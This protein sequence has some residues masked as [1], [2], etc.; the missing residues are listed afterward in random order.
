MIVNTGLNELLGVTLDGDSQT[1]DWRVGLID[2]SGFVSIYG[3]DSMASHP[4]WVENTDYDETSRPSWNPDAPADQ[5][6]SNS[7][8]VEFTM[9]DTKTI[10][11]FFISSSSTKGGSSGTLFAAVLFEEGDVDVVS[12]DVIEIT[13][14]VG[15]ARA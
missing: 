4:G 6:I 13:F 5:E 7:V 15:L 12:A 11:G 8:A 10:K 1:T 2:D 9:N 3:S 14:T